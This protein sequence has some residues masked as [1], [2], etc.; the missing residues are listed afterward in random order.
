MAPSDKLIPVERVER[1]ILVIHGQKVILD[2]ELADL[3][4]VT[5]KRLNEQVK[6]NLD[7]FPPDFT[8]Q[9]T[10]E[11]SASLRSQSA[12]LK[13]GRGQYRRSG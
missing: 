12:T 1:A 5:T 7:R 8:F 9:L 13:T 6:R 4:G 11:E 10:A 2:A 3:Y